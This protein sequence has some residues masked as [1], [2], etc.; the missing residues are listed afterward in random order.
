MTTV[1]SA[2][3]TTDSWNASGFLTC[4]IAVAFTTFDSDKAS[5]VK[6]RAFARRATQRDIRDTPDTTRRPRSRRDG[7]GTPLASEE[8]RGYF[9]GL[10]NQ[11]VETPA[12]RRARGPGG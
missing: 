10:L 11:C 2:A 6:I 8:I 12:P 4:N 7:M 5:H 9:A 1:G 3:C